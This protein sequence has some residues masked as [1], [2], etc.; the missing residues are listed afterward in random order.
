MRKSLKHILIFVLMVLL[1]CSQASTVFAFETAF[2]PLRPEV[3]GRLTVTI[4]C[5]NDNDVEEC[6]EG[7]PIEIC[8]VAN[9]DY[10]G[11]KVE[12]TLIDDF[13]GA[14]VQFSSLTASASR[15]AADK[16]SKEKQIRGIEGVVDST[17]VYGKSVF[18]DL[19]QGMYLVEQ[20]EPV[21]ADGAATAASVKEAQME[22]FII[23]VPEGQTGQW[24]YI[25]DAEPKIIAFELESNPIPDFPENPADSDNPGEEQQP[26]FPADSDEPQQPEIP[27]DSDEP[28][29]QSPA[30]SSD[31]SKPGNPDNP[32]DSQNTEDDSRSDKDKNIIKKIVD[33]V[34]TGDAA[35]VDFWIAIAGISILAVICILL[36]EYRKRRQGN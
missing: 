19:N 33:A 15:K 25:V 23:S 31:F 18:D 35:E 32:T 34:R 17:N 2:E 14:N 27:A 5:I 22:P 20:K 6:I 26:E 36:I 10:D 9:L 29:Q 4:K 13:R 1:V 30:D 21:Q 11:R 24:E 12:Y 3:K 8:R 16:L 7:V 28:Q